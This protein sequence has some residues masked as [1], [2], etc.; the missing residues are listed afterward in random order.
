MKNLLTLF[1]ITFLMISC[2]SQSS[3]GVQTIDAKSY[4]E[5]LKTIQNPQLID[6]RTLEEYD[7]EHIS[8]A[9]NI[10]WN[11]NDFESKVATYHKSEPIFVYCKVGGRSAQAA[12]KLSTLG[13]QE[14]Y[15]LDGGI[16]KWSGN[17]TTESSKKTIGITTTDYEKL[18]VSDKKVLINFYAKWCAPCKKMEP[19]ILKMQTEMKDQLTILRLDADANK[20]LLE[21]MNI[22]GLP[23]IIIYENGKEI[24][25]KIGFITEEDLKK[26]L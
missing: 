13:F 9:V 20:T 22:D 12:N 10:N 24:W 4:A 26:Q 7:V 18:I 25:R 1:A 8:G 15:N 11:G 17:K 5:K 14:I 2:Q 21:S 19:Y 3:K 23:V 16:M 6:V